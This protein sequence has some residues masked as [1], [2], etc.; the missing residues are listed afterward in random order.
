[1][2]WTGSISTMWIEDGNWSTGIA[3]VSTSNVII[4]DA[5]TT[6]NDPTLPASA[7]IMTLTLNNG[8]I[9]NSGTNSQFTL[10][11]LGAWVNKGG[12]FNAGTSTVIF[13]NSDAFIHG[14]TSFNNIIIG[15]GASLTLA[16]GAITSIAGALVNNGSFLANTFANTVEFN[17]ADQ[18]IINST[19]PAPGYGALFLSGSGIK[20]MPVSAMNITENLEISG[21]ATAIANERFSL[22]GDFTIGASAEFTTGAFIDTLNGYFYN[23]GTFNATGSTIVFNSTGTYSIGGSSGT[24]FNNLTIES[25]TATIS[26]AGSTVN[27]ILLCNGT[28][29]S[30]GNITLLSTAAQTA[31]IDG[32]G[33]GEITGNVTIQRYLP[34]SFGYKY[35]SSPFQTATVNEFADEINLAASFP[36]FYKYDESKTS[37][38][39]VKYVTTTYPLNPMEGYT[40]NFGT[41]TS[42]VTADATGVVNNGTMSVTLHNNNNAYTLGF[43]LVG[44]PYPSPINWNASSGWIKSNIDNALYYFSASTTDQYG[45]TYSSYI[46]GTSSDGNATNI[47]PSM[48]GFFIHVSNGAYPVTGVLGFSNDVRVT[49]LS[50]AFLKSSKTESPKPLL[51]LSAGYT[52]Y[53]PLADPAVIY[54]DSKATEIFDSQ[55]DAL[56]LMN[57]DTQV[58]NFYSVLSDGTKLSINGLP[59]MTDSLYVIPMGV[60]TYIN[61]TVVFKIKDTVNLSVVSGIYLTDNISGIETNLLKNKYSAYLTAGTYDTRFSIRFELSTTNAPEFQAD[62]DEFF[63]A[64]GFNNILHVTIYHLNGST[65]NLYMT[66]IAGRLIFIKTVYDEGYYDYPL[67][68]TNGIYIVTLRSGKMVRSKKIFISSHK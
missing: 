57:T 5:A 31:L 9:L 43:N 21:T 15:S 7:E 49:D 50:H 14:T 12:T 63:N 46:D 13:T 23:N 17:G 39:W 68:I 52:D 16:V 55:K 19:D 61:G 53:P 41:G 25:G 24:A 20:T 67:N 35:F 54:F 56:K 45:G 38:G 4:P 37:S 3:P 27:G 47:I 32:S 64:Y 48:Q 26:T 42:P 40:A 28:L 1:M 36:T 62:D 60:K 8:A 34:V 18:T 10:N 33:A 11:G 51:R 65:G 2:T 58:P 29:N 59:L 30:D 22:D 6:P 66:N 44:N